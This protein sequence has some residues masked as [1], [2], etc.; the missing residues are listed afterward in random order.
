MAIRPASNVPTVYIMS[1]SIGETAELVVRAAASQFA[2]A[3]INFKRKPHINSAEEIRCALEAAAQIGAAVVYTLVRQDLKEYLESKAAELDLISVD[4]MYPVIAAL[5]DITGLSPR[6]EPGLIRK[7]DKEYFA[8]VEAVEFAV[9]Y[10][11]GKSSSGLIKADLVI[12]GVSRTSKT[13]LCMYLAH[14]GIKAAN[15]PLVVEASLPD[16]LFSLPSNKIIGL[17]IKPPIL[18]EIRKQ[19]LRTM[20]LSVDTDYVNMEKIAAEYEYAWSIMRKLGCTVIDVTN[21]SV[22]ETASHVLD[23]YRKGVMTSE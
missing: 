21:K 1:D 16:E 6:N 18:Q 20:G 17:T 12:V 10:D 3:K 5:E 8:K 23:I 11:D 13:P 19:R 22:E 2:G 15:V 7:V 9:K 14:K 4:I